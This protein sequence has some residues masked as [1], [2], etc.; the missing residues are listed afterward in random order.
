MR[1]HLPNSAFIGQMKAFLE[2]CDFS[3]PDV[4]DITTN[5][6]WVSVHPAVLSLVAA[7]GLTVKPSNITCDEVTATSGH[8]LKRMKLFDMLELKSEIS[9]KEHDSSGRFIPLMRINNSDKLTEFLTEMI[10]LLHLSPEHADPIRYIVSE[11]VRNVLEHSGSKYGAIV[12]AQYNTKSNT[13]RVG[14]ADTGVGI[15]E[16]I[17]QAH[18]AKSNK[19]AIRLALIPG[20][21]GTT[22]REGGTEF[23]AGAGL[24]FIKS[25][26]Y[27]NKS[28]F[29]IYSGDAFYKLLQRKY[30]KNLVLY[31]DPT[32]D[33]HTFEEE[34]PSFKGTLVAVDISLEKTTEFT[35]LLK[36]IN[37]T[38]QQAVKERRKARYKK[39]RF[40]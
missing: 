24:F 10:P 19:D 9:I 28:P 3:N 32:K 22:R 7:L 21:T 26:A 6:K 13:I 31:A 15:M 17:N 34:L 39:A 25:I 8:Y 14:I 4:L 29:L 36:L 20:I 33:R 27:I 35:S 16:T 5:D 18:V 2:G 12:C 38:Y 40:V 30:K 1:I 11:L 37:K 23:N